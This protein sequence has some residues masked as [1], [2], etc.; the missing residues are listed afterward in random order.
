M[1]RK[2]YD[3]LGFSMTWFAVITQ[4]V[5]MV[6]N[7]QADVLET[8]IRFFSFFTILTNILVALYF[9]VRVF[10]SQNRLL[11]FLNKIGSITA[12]TVFILLVGI[13]Y[14]IVL[15]SI[16]KPEGL[17]KFV[18]ELLHTI[19]PLFVLIYWFIF[20][21]REDSNFS[22]LKKWLIYPFSYF[23]FI[24]IRGT[25]SGFYPYPFVDASVLESQQIA[26]NFILITLFVLFLFVILVFISQKT[27]SK[28]QP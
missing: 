21:K 13:V 12:I 25:F 3:T 11:L 20:S 9:S 27:K 4:L 24:I 5:L 23:I 14:Q 7:R 28:T 8:I 18:D 26:V 22:I 2:I 19:I 6:Q 10:N 17:Q 1:N 15:R 16:W